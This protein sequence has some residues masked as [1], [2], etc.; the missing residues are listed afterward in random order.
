MVYHKQGT[1]KGFGGLDLYFQNWQPQDEVKAVLVIVPGVG[2]HSGIYGNV[3]RY[4]IP[5]HFAIYSFDLRG[6]GRSPGPRGHIN[7]WAEFREDLRAFLQ[8]IKTQ[9]PVCPLFLLGH[10]LGAVVTIDYILSYPDEASALQGAIALAPALGKVGV[11]SFK[12]CLGRL[13]SRMFP[14]FTLHTGIEIDTASRDRVVLDTMVRDSLRHD[15]VSARLSTEFLATIAWI[16]EHAA[17]WQVP[18][19]ILHGG[20]DRVALPEGSRNFFAQI[21]FADKTLKE[22][23]E[24][25][26]ELYDDLDRD[27][28]MSDLENWLE[29]HL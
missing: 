20:D 25:R 17:D 8:Y 2:G 7:A 6:N 1:F 22:Y 26:H 9:E 19:L 5:K 18:L 13:L 10:S 16:H 15:Y 4:L 14:H 12:V 11:S 29:Q 23:P 28:V 21:K 24:A 3:V 27:R